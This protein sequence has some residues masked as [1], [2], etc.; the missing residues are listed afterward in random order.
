MQQDGNALVTAAAAAPAEEGRET[1]AAK[2]P[3][4]L[5]R[6]LKFL[7]YA[8]LGLGVLAIV[9]HLVW[10]RSGSG[11]WELVREKNGVKVWTLKSPGNALLLVKGSVRAKSRVSSMVY[12]IQDAPSG[13]KDSF[14]YDAEVFDRAPTP[15]GSYSAFMKFKFDIPG[16]KTRQYVLLHEYEQDPVS[17]AVSMD[18]YAAPNKLPRDPCCLRVPYLHNTWVF[19]PRGN[20]ELEI[21]LTQD[22]DDGGIPYPL[23][24]VFM[25]ENTYMVMEMLPALMQEKRYL[26]AKVDGILEPEDT[27]MGAHAGR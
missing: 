10:V 24:N 6:F 13:C 15:P 2:K 14:C 17:K 27:P 7:G 19:T 20:G 22:T 16:M 18:L 23:A 1:K 8:S 3:G 4:R 9:A 25:V 5:R 21:E 11:E 12:L 26:H